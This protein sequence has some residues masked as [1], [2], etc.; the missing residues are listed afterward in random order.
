MRDSRH[1]ATELIPGL[2]ARHIAVVPDDETKQ[3]VHEHGGVGV[4][5]RDFRQAQVLDKD[6]VSGGLEAVG[7]AQDT[8]PSVIAVACSTDQFFL[9]INAEV[10]GLS[11][12]HDSRIGTDGHPTFVAQIAQAP[13]D[14]DFQ[15]ILRL[16]THG[17]MPQDE[18]T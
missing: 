12:S 14:L 17:D 4:D 16:K 2:E 13:I 7:E 18:R 8:A 6:F 3:V 5:V 1:G 11:L 15:S 10:L 9:R